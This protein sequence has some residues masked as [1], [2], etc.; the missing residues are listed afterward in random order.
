MLGELVSQKVI[1]L[2]K[3]DTFH[4][5]YERK[6]NKLIE[7]K[8]AQKEEKQKMKD[9]EIYLCDRLKMDASSKIFHTLICRD[10]KRRHDHPPRK[11]DD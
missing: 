2:A 6:A 5:L 7:I 3:A 4:E 8:R 9:F 10:I 1:L 11:F